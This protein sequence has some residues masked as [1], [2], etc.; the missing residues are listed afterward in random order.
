VLAEQ[1]E[2]EVYALSGGNREA[3]EQALNGRPFV[4]A[5]SPQG[6]R[7]RVVVAPGASERLKAA[8]TENGAHAER[9]PPSFEDLFLSRVTA[10]GEA[11]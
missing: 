7:L 4:V 1:L 5:T 2:Y 10:H 8:V 11:A 9:V 6:S 3:L